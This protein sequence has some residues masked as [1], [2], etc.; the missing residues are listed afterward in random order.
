MARGKG[1]GNAGII[2][3]PVTGTSSD[4]VLIGSASRINGGDGNDFIS[5]SDAIERINA[6]DGDDTIYAGGGDDTIFGNDGEDTLVLDGSLRDAVLTAGKGNSYILSTAAG[7]TDTIKHIEF[8]QFDDFTYQVG[9]N[10]G[11][12][13]SADAA[14]VSEDG[15]VSI[16]VTVNDFDFEGDAF[17]ITSFEGTSANGATVTLANG[18]L[19]YDATSVAAYQSLAV[20]ETASDT[21][22]YTVTD[23]AGNSSTETV[24]VTINGANDAPEFT[25]GDTSGEITLPQGGGE[26]SVSGAT[27]LRANPVDNTNL[28]ATLDVAV[29]NNGTK[30]VISNQS[31]HANN[32]GKTF[33]SLVDTNGNETE[34]FQDTETGAS[35]SVVALDGGGFAVA[36]SSGRHNVQVK[37]FDESGDLVAEDTYFNHYA[38][39]TVG[40]TALSDGGFAVSNRQWE[41]GGYYDERLTIYDA[42]G[43]KVSGPTDLNS[44]TIAYSS[45]T[46]ITQLA[47]GGLVMLSGYG[48]DNTNP[49][50]LL[51]LD[52]D[53]AIESTTRVAAE[54]GSTGSDGS[55]VQLSD[56]SIVVSYSVRAGST[57]YDHVFEVFDA[58]GNQ[59]VEQTSISDFAYSSSHYNRASDVMALDDG[60]FALAYQNHGGRIDPATG[61]P[62][63]YG[64]YVRT[65]DANGNP[66]S[67]EI[68]VG[69]GHNPNMDIDAEGNLVVVG[70][71]HGNYATLWT[72]TPPSSGPNLSGNL[73]DSGILTAE[74]IDLSDSFVFE[75]AS[76][77][78]YGTVDVDAV[79]GEWVYTIDPDSTV[80]ADA[81]T[82]DSFEVVV[83]DEHGA[84]DFQWVHI[85]IA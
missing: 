67:E 59:I 19:V 61:Q 51:F 18:Q 48:Y 75:L 39:G 36:Y 20:G 5:G 4:D 81:A 76:D 1:K 80:I 41:G 9:V 42:S 74:D 72:V 24:T 69:S 7:G 52:G 49:L 71:G 3:N 84:T 2:N 79:T 37:T 33:V 14:S 45:N 12:F 64:I 25:G 30:V 55:L 28:T 56:G 22:T 78:Q 83:T 73:S 57:V 21:F 29:L 8:L 23:A 40:L 68:F 65:F 63:Q 50:E 54:I 35:Q 26:A 43:A 34:I 62:S 10:N 70:L 13:T 82:E 6:G 16:D 27:V 11:V 44:A 47:D 32:G 31:N 38:D 77:A 60:G 53:G 17:S 15:S 58:Q 46:A 85:D 66:A